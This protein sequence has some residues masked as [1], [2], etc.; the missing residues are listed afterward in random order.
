MRRGDIFLVDFDP[1]RGAEVDKRRPA[2]VVS[3]EG[4][5]RRIVE[6][7]WGVVNVVPLSTQIENVRRFQVL[8]PARE[9]GLE[10]DSKAQTEQVRAVAMQR[11]QQRL[12]FVPP[13][14]MRQ[15]DEALRIQLAL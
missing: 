13:L 14:L 2:V 7:N 11:V 6:L 3:N 4:T 1:A 8:I 10:F 15:I 5:N 12:G 9:S